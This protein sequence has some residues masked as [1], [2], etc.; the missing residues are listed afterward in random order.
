MVEGIKAAY[1]KPIVGTID[2]KSNQKKE[3]ELFIKQ[4]LKGAFL[5]RFSD[6]V[7]ISGNYGIHSMIII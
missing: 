4:K 6:L 1:N 2:R 3:R 5:I 7:L